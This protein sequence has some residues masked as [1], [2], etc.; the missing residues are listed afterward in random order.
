M[1]SLAGM[2]PGDV[3]VE[4]KVWGDLCHVLFNVKEFIFVN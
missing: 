2:P 3:A 4:T 1:Y